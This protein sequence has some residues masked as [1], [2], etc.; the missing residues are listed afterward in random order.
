M[1]LS[2]NLTYITVPWVNIY[3]TPI[4]IYLKRVLAFMGAEDWGMG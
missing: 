3:C 4:H 1:T 2:T